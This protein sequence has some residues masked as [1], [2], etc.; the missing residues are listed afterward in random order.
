MQRYLFCIEKEKNSTLFFS[1]MYEQLNS[2]GK[3]ND[4]ATQHGHYFYYVTEYECEKVAISMFYILRANT[5]H[6]TKAVS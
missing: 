2:V 6:S 1:N 3:N 5:S 4:Q